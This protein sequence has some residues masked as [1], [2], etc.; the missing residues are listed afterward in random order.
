MTTRW[1]TLTSEELAELPST[2]VLHEM[3]QPIS[4]REILYGADVKLP[5][6]R[7]LD[8]LKKLMASVLVPAGK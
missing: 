7:S 4:A 8:G 6:V 5:P 1:L 3:L 2:E